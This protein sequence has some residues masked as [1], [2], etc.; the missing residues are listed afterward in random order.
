MGLGRGYVGIKASTRVDR[1]V[2]TTKYSAEKALLR[3][4]W[5]SSKN[6][7]KALL[8]LDGRN[9]STVSETQP[10]T[11]FLHCFCTRADEG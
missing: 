8:N 3:L 6:D 11:L 9:V 10:E 7:M 1:V 5:L 4:G 2:S